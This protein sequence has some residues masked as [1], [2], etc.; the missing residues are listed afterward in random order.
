VSS[1]WGAV[2]AKMGHPKPFNLKYIE[3]GNE[4]E[5]ATYAD[6]YDLFR[7]AIKAK[8]P[9]ITVIMSMY[10]S[11]LNRGVL[12]RASANNVTIDM[13]DEHAYHAIEWPRQNFNYFDRY[14]RTRP[15][16]LFVGEYSAQLNR[17]NWGGG[18][19][20]AVYLMMMER[21][22]D[23]VQLA[24]YAPLFVNVNDRM[25]PVNLIE[26]DA[27]RSF[28]HGS[29]YVQKTFNENR[30]DVDLATT[31]D[32]SPKPTPTPTP[33]PAAQA[34]R[35]G[36]GRGRGPAN[37]PWFFSTAGLDR[38]NNMVVVKAANYQTT[39]VPVEIQ[40]DGVS[41]VGKTG[42]MIT[43]S[44]PNLTGDNTLDNPKLI[45]PKEQTLNNCAQ[46]FTVTLAPLSVN[47]LRIPVRGK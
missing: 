35:R 7:K 13:V 34:A 14:D 2:R 36:G 5:I 1:K 33:D 42:T 30:P 15:W 17:G 38:K 10:W 16:K 40:L 29:Y 24:A 8:Y 12:N 47:V 9:E 41:S 11:G 37:L 44:G 18:M 22:G 31:T 39:P 20:D 43:I 25:W 27:S 26:Y 23:L 3:I 28:A 32:F 21:N 19:G 46:K 6:N 4:H 45:V